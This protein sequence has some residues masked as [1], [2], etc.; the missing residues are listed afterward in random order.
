[1]GFFDRNRKRLAELGIDP[2]R[3]PPGQYLTDRFPVLHVGDVPR[4]DLDHWALEVDGL[5]RSPYTLSFAELTAMPAVEITT[6][7]HCV[8]KWSK[9]DTH[10][11]GVR[12]RDLLERAGLDARASHV[13]AHA[14]HGYTANLP[15]DA[16]LRDD[17]L[18]AWRF[19][20]EPLE[21]RH[22]FPARLVVPHLYFWKSVKWLRGIEVLDR[23][24]KGFW[25]RNG[26]HNEGDPWKEQRTSR[27]L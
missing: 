22:G 7:V 27:W 16:L 8:T 15:L 25:E 13:V 4:Y 1:V 14:E 17:A 23:D 24:R 6:D 19:G 12:A 3:L 20:G 10:W 21:P 5:V 2:R 18:V 9:F 11:T 26:Y